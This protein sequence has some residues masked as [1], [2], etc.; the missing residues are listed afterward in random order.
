MIQVLV[1]IPSSHA[2]CLSTVV[3]VTV[4]IMQ[5]NVCMKNIV[6]TVHI[7]QKKRYVRRI[8]PFLG[9]KNNYSMQY[10]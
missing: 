5:K 6:V 1:C 2:A 7:K 4:N 8:F 10:K 9:N 3:V